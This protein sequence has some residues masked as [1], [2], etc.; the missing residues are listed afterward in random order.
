MLFKCQGEIKHL[1]CGCGAVVS[2]EYPKGVVTRFAPFC[3]DIT[4]RPPRKLAKKP[5]PKLQGRFE[6]FPQAPRK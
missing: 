5:D 1:S 6:G 4:H 2:K 3:R